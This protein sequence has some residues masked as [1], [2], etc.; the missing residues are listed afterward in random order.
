M[1]CGSCSQLGNSRSNTY[2]SWLIDEQNVR[3]PVPTP[4]A[5]LCT[6]CAIGHQNDLARS[7][8]CKHADHAAASRAAVDPDGQRCC[9]RILPCLCKPE[10]GVDRVVLLDRLQ[11]K[12]WQANVTGELLLGAE[13]RGTSASRWSLVGNSD[14]LIDRR[15]QDIRVLYWWR[16]LGKCEQRCHQQTRDDRVLHF[17]VVGNQCLDEDW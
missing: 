15:L 7:I 5:C 12:W 16:K 11:R 9:F 8:L 2:L 13:C 4:H 14:I 3:A 6:V 10:E 1:Y 17:C